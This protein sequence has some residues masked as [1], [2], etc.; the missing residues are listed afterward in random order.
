MVGYRVWRRAGVVASAGETVV[1]DATLE[2]PVAHLDVR[3]DPA[4]AELWL[5]DTRLG[6]TPFAARLPAALDKNRIPGVKNV[7]AVASGKGGVGKSTVATNLALALK[8]W[9]AKVGMWTPMCSGRR[10]RR[11]WGRPS[12]PPAARPRSG[13][14]RRSILACASSR[15]ASSSSAA[16]P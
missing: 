16:G 4:G 9:G 12:S 5:D 7:I 8:R 11:C 14:A 3:S 6:E 15:S 13:S 1:L 2:R 10:S